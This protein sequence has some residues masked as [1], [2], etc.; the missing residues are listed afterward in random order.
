MKRNRFRFIVF[1]ALLAALSLIV[2]S[3]GA[4]SKDGPVVTLGTEQTEYTASQEV[5]ITVAIANP[6]KHSVRILKWFTPVDGVVEPVFTVKRDG[7]SVLYTGA[8]YKRP[9][10]TGNDYLTLKS[11]ESL[12]YVINLGEFYDLSASGQYTISY[13]ARAYNLYT[14]KGNNAANPET[15]TSDTIS[16]KIEGRQPKKPT[17]PPPPPSGGT[18]FSNCTTTQ[19]TILNQ[20]RTQAT[21]YANEA[22]TYLASN[23]NTPRYVTWFGVYDA[24]RFSQVNTHFTSLANAWTNAGVNFDCKC[25]QPYYAYVYPDRPY[26]IYLCKVFWSAPLAGT[27][28]QGGT[29]IHEMSHFYVVASTE[30]YVYGQSGA[31]D[32]A[33]ANPAEAIMNADNH[34]Y[35]AENNPYKP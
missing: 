12:T 19:Q 35:F 2:G 22:K 16:L 10:A 30:D 20:A 13:D 9:P 4:A 14:E 27:D 1:F 3:V 6:T 25:K 31:M 24:S 18:A 21:T 34:E 33:A 11:G 23:T 28:S 29:L 8:I 7:S 26:N 32:L 17:T 15:L 5:L